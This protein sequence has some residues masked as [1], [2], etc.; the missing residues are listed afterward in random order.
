M[1]D[2]NQVREATEAQE[3]TTAQETAETLNTIE[4]QITDDAQEAKEQRTP[5]E[6]E[7]QEAL[8]VLAKAG[9]TEMRDA[10]MRLTLFLQS[11]AYKVIGAAMEAAKVIETLNNGDL[12]NLTGDEA[13][14]WD[15]APY[16]QAELDT[17]PQGYTITDIVR[18]S[19]DEHGN[20]RPSRFDAIIERARE[21]QEEFEAAA[22]LPRINVKT[23]DT[24]NY[25]TDK[26]NA[27]IWDL[28]TDAAETTPGGQ[29]RWKIDTSP[30]KSKQDTIILYGIDFEE[31]PAGVKITKQLTQYD[32]R[33]HIAAAALY[34]AG[35]EIT[36]V[37]QIYSAMGNSGK[38]KEGDIKKIYD[39][40]TK[41]GAAHVYIDNS[42]EAQTL[43]GYDK[44]IYDGAL[45]PFE[46]VSAYINGKLTESAIHLFR[47]P[48]L[49]TFARQRSQITTIP[50]KVL[51]SP[52]N[53]TDANLL[54]DDYLLERIGRMKNPKNNAKRKMLF[55]TI[56]D[57]CKIKTPM[58]KQRAPE[59]IRRYLEHY[60]K[61]GWI[62]GYT[63]DKD[64]ITIQL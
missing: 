18:E 36:S 62:K 50:R 30:N 53:K 25:P 5:E 14:L 28:I 22:D 35:N 51:E 54:I 37:T 44:F 3:T 58:Q 11:N 16:I 45:L 61:C 46:R 34:N 7:D 49:M 20:A 21:K 27:V 63:E 39:S 59:K 56:Y 24:I 8:N 2:A 41:M 15:I 47:E 42:Q 40:L 57:H 26:P 29:L 10:L 23:A 33:V 38:P 9:L 13:E 32:K 31:L 55:A 6:L 52:I 4:A 60:K 43:K 12:T 17:N 19:L 1:Q 64:G 48:P